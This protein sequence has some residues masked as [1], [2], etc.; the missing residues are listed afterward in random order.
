MWSSQRE[1]QPVQPLCKRA[2][3]FLKKLKIHS[4]YDPAAPC[5]GVY[6]GEMKTYVDAE[7]GSLVFRVA[8]F[9]IR[10]SGKRSK[11]LSTSRWIN[12]HPHTGTASS[13]KGKPLLGTAPGRISHALRREEAR[14]KGSR[15]TIP[16]HDIPE[17][18]NHG[19]RNQI[20]GRQPPGLGGGVDY[21]RA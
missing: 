9:M 1:G 19:D 7:I 17:E 5:L 2:G 21:E 11:C 3:Q 18:A 10:E 8:L 16:R 12:R 20:T 4:P 15:R 14:I 13:I 6:P